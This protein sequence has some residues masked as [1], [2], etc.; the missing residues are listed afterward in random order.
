MSTMSFYTI[1]ILFAKCK[2]IASNLR[3]SWSSR[4]QLNEEFAQDVEAGL[5][6]SSF[7][8]LSHNQGDQ[9]KGFDEDSKVK[10][11][12]LIERD[13]LDFDQARLEYMR[14]NFQ[15]N[16]IAPDGTPIDPKAV[17]FGGRSLGT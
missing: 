9:R 8:V 15:Q 10:I 17:T 1:G 12:E 2:N 16:S 13:G 5:I 7:D 11:Q 3:S 14:Q 4:I 6:S